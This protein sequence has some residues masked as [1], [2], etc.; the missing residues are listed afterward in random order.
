MKSLS[1]SLL[2]AAGL[3]YGLP[4]LAQNNAPQEGVNVGKM[5]IMRKIVPSG[6]LE[7]Q[8]AQQYMQTMQTAQQ[9]RELAPDNHPQVIRL[10]AIAKKMI[11]FALPWNPRAKEWK[12]EVNLIASTQINAYCM[13]GG[14]IAFYTGILDTLKLTDDEVAMIMGHEIAHA[15]REHGAERAGKSMAMSGAAK[16]LG[17]FAES[18]GYDGNM[19]AGIAGTAGNVAMLKF[20]RE[21][22]TEGDIVGMDLA[23]RSGFDPR[24]GVTLWQ[25][26]GLVNQKA[27]PKWLSTHPAGEDRIKEIR[28][29][30]PEVM[31]LYARA[32][33][34]SLANLPPYRSN[35]KGIPD[36]Q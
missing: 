4:V 36:V 11:P 8:A 7:G 33:G 12:W 1:T 30:F 14:K 15:L 31:P 35:V 21:D 3:I 19:V 34:V 10:R 28:K 6:A 18:K 25:K 23:A 17:I 13:P 26:M 22:E 2:L 5:S 29:H 9:K 27:P 32:K 16:L 24:A 20:S